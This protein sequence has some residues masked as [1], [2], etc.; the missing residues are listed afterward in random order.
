[1]REA[2]VA[3]A[4]THFQAAPFFYVVGS[5]ACGTRLDEAATGSFRSFQPSSMRKAAAECCNR[6][7]DSWQTGLPAS[8]ESVTYCAK[9]LP[10][11]STNARYVLFRDRLCLRD[12]AAS[13]AP[14]PA[15]V[16]RQVTAFARPARL[17]PQSLRYGSRLHDSSFEA[18]CAAA[19]AVINTHAAIHVPTTPAQAR[20]NKHP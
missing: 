17:P 12:G 5:M 14:G 9:P 10:V 13:C 16:K 2:Y 8:V 11:M 1:M 15:D 7:V 6:T 19:F 18:R 20:G 3:G 4:F